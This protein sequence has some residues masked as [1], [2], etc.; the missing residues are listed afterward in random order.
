MAAS[1]ISRLIEDLTADI[2]SGKL[3]PGSPLPTHRQLA[4]KNGIAIASASKVYTHLK[5]IGL[6]V[7]ETGRGTFV[8]DRPQQ[9]EW[10]AGDEARQNTHAVD[11]SFNHPTWPAQGDMLR[12]M[13]RE[14]SLSGDLAALLHQQPPG[15]RA[16]ERRIVA[17]F[18]AQSRSIQT[19]ADGLFL[20]NGAQQGL[21]ITTRALL[22]PGDTVAVDALT[23]P[24]FKMVAQTQHLALQPVRSLPDGPD[25]DA[26]DAL[27]QRKPVR[28]IYVMPTMHNP[29]GWVLTTGQRRH[30][31]EIARHYDCL[32]I[33]DASYAYLAKSSP[34]ALVTLAPERTI[35]IASLSKSL[36]SGLRFGFI[37]APERYRLPIKAT[38]RASYWKPAE[39]HN[40][41]R[42]SLDCG[43]HRCSP[44]KANASG[45]L[46][47]AGYCA[48]GAL[49]DGHH[50]SSVFSI[51]MAAA[52]VRIENGPDRHCARRAQHRSFQSHCLFDHSACATRLAI[53]FKL[54]TVGRPALGVGTSAQHHRALSD[55]ISG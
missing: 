31:A 21:D 41:H 49:R 51:F 30:L 45:S 46:E 55:L 47:A 2:R 35:Y 52:P 7:G 28:A 20:V 8:R 10:D 19:E 37:V 23:Y 34:P 50:R 44:R 6:V 16:H 22:S 36:A 33:E 39:S 11:L 14:L 18:L 15:G 43:R 5:A 25:L 13:L 54:R 48:P 12:K 32:I 26:L 9:R 4:R 3:P 1:S 17:D 40:G 38:I 24:G 29:L 53:G 42:D 27:C